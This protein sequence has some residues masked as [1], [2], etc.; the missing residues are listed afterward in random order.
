MEELTVG[1]ST[2]QL[3]EKV[4]YPNG[5]TSLF[6]VCRNAVIIL[7][8]G[9]CDCPDGSIFD[10][11]LI[12][13]KQNS[14]MHRYGRVFRFLKEDAGMIED[15]V[16]DPQYHF[17]NEEYRVYSSVDRSDSADASPL[18]WL[19]EQDFADV[20]GMESLQYLQKEYCIEDSAGHRYFLDYLVKTTQGPIAVEENGI[21]YHHPQ[22]I[23]KEQYRDQLRKQNTC[24]QWGIRLYRFSTDDCSKNEQIK[25]DIRSFFGSD[26]SRFIANGLVADRAV[27]LYDHQADALDDMM[28]KRLAGYSAFLLVLPTASGKSRIAE[29]DMARC[30]REDPDFRALIMAP[31]QNILDDWQQRIHKDLPWLENKVEIHSYQ[32][33]MRNYD[34]MDPQR[35]TYE[36]CDEAH[37]TVAPVIRRVVQYFTPKCLLGLT[38]TD[39]R[40]DRK[41]LESVFGTYNTQLSLEDAMKKHIVAQASVFRIETNLDLSKVRINGRDYVNAD[42]E[43]S[44]RVTSRNDLIGDVLQKYFTEGEA[45][46]LQGIVFC[47]N[48]RHTK[49]ME[50]VLND[51]GIPAKAYTSREA[52]A[53]RLMRDFRDHKYR[54]LCACNM[55]SEGWDYPE[56]GILVMARPTLSKVL[57]LQQIGRGLRKTRTKS[58]VFVLDVVDEYGPMA[59]A[60][61]MHALF[62]NPV[63]VPFGLITNRTYQIGD[64][65]EVEGLH[66][67]VESIQPADIDTFEEKYGGYLNQ[68]QLAREFFLST[69]SITKWIHDGK[70]TPDVEIPFGSRKIFLFS[71]E[72]AERIR[73]Q[74][75]IPV[76][77]DDTIRKDFFDFL[78]E[79]DYSLSYKMPFLLSLLDQM[80]GKGDADIGKVLEQ[81]IAFYRDRLDRGLPV[82]RSTCPYTAERLS[83][84]KFMKNSMLT[85][86]FEKF[87]RKRFLYYTNDRKDLN[88]ISMN[89]A[90][91]ASLSEED[92]TRIRG[93]MK[94]DLEN[95]YRN[96]GGV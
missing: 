2:Y 44:I 25:D 95:Y 72:N 22:I 65:I 53:D 57:Y 42:L 94:Q 45:G 8:D 15:M 39:Q 69:G 35:Y 6:Y 24:T 74:F 33:M 26:P 20:Y 96:L 38:A 19:F 75:H 83:D 78:E 41:R 37:H 73:N 51:R 9:I 29:E 36:V 76:H 5:G 27:Q 58:S 56:L 3:L 48:A 90:L 14:Y 50:K 79:R 85:N 68:E 17:L 28:K 1:K 62:H 82:D 12:T 86:P 88:V 93:Q 87:E 61:N 30:A 34:R 32:Y 60:V 71:R 16:L 4:R 81:Y 52:H 66:E 64:V 31:N 43:K 10:Y 80:D 55:I 77:N 46:R 89:H 54:F 21:R 23:G 91:L 92:R 63:Y 13:E 59:K 47:V 7:D 11:S 67:T 70:I 40:P 84:P 18:E 49:E